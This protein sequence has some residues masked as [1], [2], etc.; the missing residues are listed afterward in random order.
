MSNASAVFFSIPELTSE[1]CLYLMASDILKLKLTSR[2][3]HTTCRPLFWNTLRLREE[4]VSKRFTNVELNKEGL[5][6]L[7][8]NIDSVRML[9]TKGRFLSLY[10]I[11]LSKYLDENSNNDDYNN[12]KGDTVTTTF[13]LEQQWQQQQ[14]LLRRPEWVPYVLTPETEN[15][16][17]LPP[18]TKL[19]SFRVSTVSG[20]IWEQERERI[21]NGSRSTLMATS[22][23]LQ[24]CWIMTLN[25]NLTYVLLHGL[26]LRDGRVVRCLADAISSLCHLKDITIRPGNNLWVK[27]EVVNI[28]FRSCPSSLVSLKM[29]LDT[30]N[31]DMEEALIDLDSKDIDAGP[32][33][34]RTE[35][36]VN[37]RYLQLPDSYYG[38]TAKEICPFL[39]HCPRLESWHLPLISESAEEEAIIKVIQ[40]NCRELKNL[41]EG[42]A[43]ADLK[44]AFVTTVMEAVEEQ[45]LET[46]EYYGYLNDP[47]KMAALFQRHCYVLQKI[48]ITG[49]DCMESPIIHGILTS[50]RELR[51]L[52]I[53]GRYSNQIALS[54]EDAGSGQEWACRKLRHLMVY[55]TVPPTSTESNHLPW[56]FLEQFYRHLGSLHELEFLDLR[57]AGYRPYTTEGGEIKERE[58]E[59]DELTFPGLFSLGDPTTGERGFLSL[60]KNLKRLKTFQGSLSWNRTRE[61]EPRGQK[62]MEWVVEHWPS[63]KMFEAISHFYLPI[64]QHSYP[65]FTDVVANKEGLAAFGRNI[66][67][68]RTFQT[69]GDFMTFY[70]VGLDRYLKSNSTSNSSDNDNDKRQV[71][72]RPGWVPCAT[73]KESENAPMLP[74]FTKL[75]SFRASMLYGDLLDWEH[76]ESRSILRAAPLTLQASWIISLNPNLTNVFL[77]GADL[78]NDRVVRCL[79][80]VISSLRH[81]RDLTITP[82]HATRL[83]HQVIDIIFRSCPQSMVRLKLL[84]DAKNRSRDEGPID[85]NNDDIDAGPVVLRTEPLAN[86]RYLQLPDKY[87]GYTAEQIC[88]FLEHCPRLE[89]WVVPCIAESAES[90]IANVIRTKCTEFKHY[91][92]E[93]PYFNY[94]GAFAMTILETTEEQQMETF[95]FASYNDEWAERMSASIRRHCEVLQRIK[96]CGCHRLESSTIHTILISCRGLRYL[97]INGY[98]PNKI[99]LSL[100]DA[101]SAKEWVCT[102]LRHWEI[103]VGVPSTS[104][105]SK[106]L[107]WDL[108]EQFYR[109]LGSLHEL[110]FLSL[111]GT[112]NSSYK[113]AD[114][115]IK[116]KTIEYDRLSFPGL[117]S[118]GDP[119]TGEPGF[120][121]FLK[122]LSQLTTFQGSLLWKCVREEEPRG[123]KEME[124]LVEHWPLLKVYEI[125]RYDSLPLIRNDFPYLKWL[126]EQ[127]PQLMAQKASSRN[128]IHGNNPTPII[129]GTPHVT[130]SVPNVSPTQLS[131]GEPSPSDAPRPSHFLNAPQEQ[132]NG[133]QAQVQGGHQQND[134]A[135]AEA[136]A[137]ANTEAGEPE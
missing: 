62:E 72:C 54:L 106:P 56:D 104:T 2:H 134:D 93:T 99:A 13:S 59:Y 63:L 76:D 37:L 50:C 77:Y 102:K 135:G 125:T 78:E 129:I 12:S 124:W 123:Q 55:V 45:Q 34:L 130:Y 120:L 91:I 101:G 1:L 67:S 121:S 26:N 83:E 126:E 42:S 132:A 18:F 64:T 105:D 118:L 95:I 6:A 116:E 23:S 98:Y 131:Y 96:L 92:C 30:N 27:Y 7:G 17:A 53:S 44:G 100:E 58:S 38:Y 75:T 39:E 108:L 112:G 81:L 28:L 57:G 86:L 80:R 21:E 107:P 119:A 15:A 84:M 5:A 113:S 122:N 24:T 51:Y 31:D 14:Q 70:I 40:A 36:L 22:L 115:E 49:C 137:D 79:S 4:E 89:S 65:R 66:D 46:V 11:G 127:M 117:F 94:K 16:P 74:P 90:E 52:E 20:Y 3:M 114:G 87:N 88:P 35:P 111:K 71:I 61:E 41:L 136:G 8:R 60:F 128:H 19:T 43:N 85:L 97:V 29:S 48:A 69:R 33:V 109:H 32:V 133:G 110:E 10:T 47:G 25:P 82:S 68:V 73:I 9:Q 103:Y